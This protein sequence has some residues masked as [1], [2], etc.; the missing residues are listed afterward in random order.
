MGEGEYDLWSERFFP[1][2]DF[3]APTVLRPAHASDGLWISR[4]TDDGVAGHARDGHE[5]AWD[6]WNARYAGYAGNARYGYVWHAAH[7]YA[8]AT[9]RRRDAVVPPLLWL[10]VRPKRGEP[11]Y[12]RWDVQLRPRRS[13]RLWR[14]IWTRQKLALRSSTTSIPTPPT[15]STSSGAIALCAII[16]RPIGIWVRRRRRGVD[17]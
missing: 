5:H 2:I 14:G 3:S 9:R 17:L 1:S 13:V 16:L 15:P 6:A 8:N 7:G 12:R 10:D 4:H 11:T